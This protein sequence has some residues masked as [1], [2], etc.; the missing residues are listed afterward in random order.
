MKRFLPLVFLF[1]VC[2]AKVFAVTKI[3]VLTGNWNNAAVWNPSGVPNAADDVVIQSL[4][5]IQLNADGF[6]KSITINAN[7]ELNF[8]AGKKLSINGNVIVNGKLDMNGGD[9]AQQQSSAQ[10]VITN[11]GK[12][13]WNPAD[14]SLAGASLFTN[15][16]ENFS[17]QS[18]LIIKKWYA[19]ASVAL[20]DV[21]TGN[22]GN[23]IIN[24]I[25]GGVLFEWNQKNQFE[26]HK[27][28]GTLTI[29]QG[30]VVLDKSGAISN[31]TI[32]SIVLLNMNS[33]LDLHSGTH[34]GSFTVNTDSIINI[35]G[36]LNG[37]YNGNGNIA[38]N[39][40][41]N[42]TNMGNVELIYNTGL[43]NTGLG[44][45]TVNVGGKFKQT[46]GDFRGIFNLSTVNSGSITM[47]FGSVEQ[48]GG[49]M[50]GYYACNSSGALNKITVNG[51]LAI[52]LTNTNDKFRVNGLTSLMGQYSKS[53]AVLQ[54]NGTITLSGN[55]ASEFTTSGSVGAETVHVAGDVIING[56]ANN[57]NYGSHAT[58]IVIDGK[59]K[60]YGGTTSLSKFPGAAQVTIG[61]DLIIASGTLA[62]KGNNGVADVNVNGNF[63][64]S[65]G[66]LLMHSNTTTATSDAVTF[67]LQG[68]FNQLNGTLC[69]DDNAVSTATHQ[70][71][72]KGN[73]FSVDGGSQIT[74]AG[75]GTSSVFGKLIFARAG[76]LQYKRISATTLI[77]QTKQ[78]I[79]NSC[80]VDVL[81][82]SF[83]LSSHQNAATDFL[84]I[85]NNGTLQMHAAQII[86]NF[87]AAHTGMSIDAGGKLITQ[88]SNGFYNSTGNATLKNTGGLNY[89]LDAASTVEYNGSDN[90]TITGIND[91]MATA[92]QH[93]YGILKIN[94]TGTTNTEF[95]KLIN[96]NVYVR[97]QLLLENGELNL[98]SNT[99]TIES[100]TATA[101]GRVNGYIKSEAENSKLKFK[102][103]PHSNCII[104]FGI[105]AAEYIPLE[106]N[107]ISGS[108]EVVFSTYH[109]SQNNLPFPQ[110]VAGLVID[111][112]D[113]A[114]PSAI[115]RWYCIKAGNIKADIKFSFS[116]YENTTAATPGEELTVLSAANGSWKSLNTQGT[117][118]GTSVTVNNASDVMNCAI[119]LKKDFTQTIFELTAAYESDN[120]SGRWSFSPEKPGDSYTVE[121]S[122]DNQSFESIETKQGDGTGVYEFTDS[123][124]LDATS[125]Y[126]VKYSG[127][128]GAVKY[129]NVVEVSNETK[130]GL[131]S[132]EISNVYPNP[133]TSA[134]TLQY[135]AG[136]AGEMKIELINEAGQ[137]V[138]TGR[139][140][141]QSGL[142][143]YIYP[144]QKPLPVGMYVLV[145]SGNKSRATKKVYKK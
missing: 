18:T 2:T 71:L 76:I 95:T 33:F 5:K 60:I 120:V 139:Q 111:G 117:T 144:N 10:F 64:Q 142:N 87:K 72:L 23:V 3:S 77:E 145:V 55:A 11:T 27:V 25:V 93:K 51:D 124:P 9:I 131:A 82:G 28:L 83:Q 136:I 81:A 29:D 19:F 80:T 132:L 116:S 21:V 106:F 140:D 97:N 42:F 102:N 118:A 54:V 46:A 74:R 62:I 56:L 107:A 96:S 108:G 141:C 15:S 88:N 41:G 138:F 128:N 69:F 92:V 63:I 67:V 127:V 90:Q 61:S 20:G 133:F 68:I 134:F 143:T 13:T 7:A 94:F 24:T 84:R 70:L 34:P 103:I 53:K 100:N 58:D 35:G 36:E 137:L 104:P 122:A 43:Q 50:M 40:T 59:L 78:H 45:C 32:G 22:F 98:N 115:D 109:T 135:H 113:L 47:S 86:T 14:N 39:V 12:F 85:E 75:A 37:I 30:W 121:R 119:V 4:H 6:A 129:S 112:K 79:G 26:T 125:Y 65:G 89:F 73:V 110:N 16:T 126:R 114:I 49:V 31:T 52:S 1:A 17:A 66:T 99:L 57:F 105:N 101:I 38:L 130:P 48:T 123:N 8:T 91:G 44:N